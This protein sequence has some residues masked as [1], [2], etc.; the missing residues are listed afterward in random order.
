MLDA[1]MLVCVS[2]GWQ[3]DLLQ[4]LEHVHFADTTAMQSEKCQR[5]V[6]ASYTLEQQQVRR[7]LYMCRHTNYT[8]CTTRNQQPTSIPASLH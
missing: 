2:S 5:R 6:R 8:A 7:L 3:A 4:A 1:R